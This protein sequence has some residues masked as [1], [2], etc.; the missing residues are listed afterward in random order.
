MSASVPPAAPPSPAG[1]FLAD[2]IQTDLR[3]GRH[4]TVVT[5][6]PPEPNGYLHIGHAKSICLNFGLALQFGG[7][8]HMR[9]DDTNP[10]KEDDEYVQAILRDVRWLGFDWGE[11][12]HSASDTFEACYDLA[13]GLIQDGK[14]YV[15]SQTEEEIRATRGTVNEVGRLSPFRSRSTAENLDLFARMR[16]GEFPEGAHVVRGKGDMS[17]ANMKLRD[18]LLY[19]IRHADHHKTGDTWC[20]Y[21]M[22]DYAHPISDALE[23][24]THSICTLEF[25]NNRDIYDWVIANCRVGIPAAQRPRQYE[26]ARLHL[27]YV[28]VSKRKLLRL[29]QENHVRGWD[30]PRMPTLAGQRRRGVTPEAI[31]LFCERI[32][33][34]KANSLVDYETYEVAIRDDLNGRAP[35]GMAVL[36]PLRVTIENWPEGHVEVLD[37]PLWPPEIGHE[38]SRSLR[39]SGSVWIDRSD[40]ME[41]PPKKFFRLAPGTE[42]RLR[43]GFIIRCTGVDH[44]DA[45][46]VIGL[47]CTYDPASRGGNPSDGRKV[48]GTIQWV[49]VASGADAEVRIYE[50]LFTVERPDAADGDF[51]DLVN[52]NALRVVSAK[53]E[54]MLAGCAPGER[55]QFEREGYFIAD[56][57]DSRPGAPVFNRTVALKDSWAKQAG[58]S[59]ARAVS[60]DREVSQREASQRAAA[61]VGGRAPESRVRDS[62]G[63]AAFDRYVLLGLSGADAGVLADDA[64]LSALFDQALSVFDDAKAV[65]NLVINDVAALRKSRGFRASGVQIGRVGD[66]VDQ[67]QI[68]SR[69]AKD[70]LLVLATES[71]DAASIVKARGWTVVTN[72]GPIEAAARDV[73]SAHPN[74][75]AAYCGGKSNLLG[76]F[77]GKV[78]KA[79]GG[80]AQP[81]TVQEIVRGML[82]G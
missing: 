17:A 15:D 59:P 62:V 54:P 79:T 48:Q 74:E 52:P 68:T 45:G 82:D 33:V 55:F 37:A 23:G 57:I 24:V 63:T 53:V 49:D 20:I 81:Q 71:G 42:V 28:I 77:V 11:H 31:R 64:A 56:E 4:S 30:D 70:L 58:V 3:S 51:V 10:S 2:L 60:G 1:N 80:T 32:G 76:F 73:L 65:A 9:F 26:F 50:R 8:C 34:A 6:F 12:L 39:F 36:N 43:Y 47:R 40:F 27:S 35:R 7:R 72:R 13:V 18:P 61:R 5:R 75:V 66:L 21:P 44:D 14:A 41:D 25:E 29:V 22:Y 69:T 67:G 16:A 46:E 19:R 78:M 38:G